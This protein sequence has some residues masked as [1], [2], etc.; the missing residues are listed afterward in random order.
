M[1]RGKVFLRV[2]TCVC[3]RVCV[4]LCSVLSFSSSMLVSQRCRDQNGNED[5]GTT[6]F[7]VDKPQCSDYLSRLTVFFVCKCGTEGAGSV[8]RKFVM[9]AQ[10]SFQGHPAC[11][12]CHIPPGQARF[13]EHFSQA[14]KKCMPWMIPRN[15]SRRQLLTGL[16]PHHMLTS[17]FACKKTLFVRIMRIFLGITYVMWTFLFSLQAIHHIPHIT[18]LSVIWMMVS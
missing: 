14:M 5:Q 18:H 7:K 11:I 4:C 8:P 6:S 2:C 12:S 15:C 13:P 1:L 9:S 10:Y 3:V 16:C 17:N